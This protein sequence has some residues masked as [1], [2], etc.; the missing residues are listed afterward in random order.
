MNIW[1]GIESNRTAEKDRWR[2]TETHMY[3][4]LLVWI[5]MVVVV[6]SPSFG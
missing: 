4:W 6:V 5:H 1:N 3:E 2:D